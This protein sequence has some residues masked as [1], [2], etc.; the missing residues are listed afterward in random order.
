MRS[1][2]RQGDQRFTF[3]CAS[4]SGDV[5]HR[6]LRR[7]HESNS[8][9]PIRNRHVD[10]LFVTVH[11]VRPR[12]IPQP[13]IR[14]PAVCDTVVL[15]VAPESA[16]RR[17]RH[18]SC[19]SIAAGAATLTDRASAVTAGAAAPAAATPLPPAAASNRPRADPAAPT[20][21]PDHP[22]T[23]PA[24]PAVAAAIRFNAQPAGLTTLGSTR[25]RVVASDPG[26]T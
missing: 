13:R 8:R 9:N 19:A 18:R 7:L 24:T 10:P 23:D 11:T 1:T 5:V 6:V 15:A 3:M 12:S 14:H 25:F 16:A 21:D 2:G 26:R 20:A 17:I 4:R 22:A